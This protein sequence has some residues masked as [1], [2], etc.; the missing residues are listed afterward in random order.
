[1]HNGGREGCNFLFLGSMRSNVPPWFQFLPLQAAQRFG[2][3][4]RFRTSHAQPHVRRSHTQNST[5]TRI[6]PLAR[7]MRSTIGPTVQ[8]C[9]EP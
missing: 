4:R 1:M 3:R 6:D 7:L 2:V 9:H 5:S 8:R